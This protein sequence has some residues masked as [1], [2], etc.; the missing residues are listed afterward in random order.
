MQVFSKSFASLLLLDKE[1]NMII[2][3][4]NLTLRC[5]YIASIQAVSKKLRGW[6]R[7]R[8]GPQSEKKMRASA[9]AEK[10]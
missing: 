6:R 8:A 7:R 1:A 10:M 9:T 5:V 4:D 2:L 3:E